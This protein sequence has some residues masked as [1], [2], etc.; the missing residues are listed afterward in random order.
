MCE[1]VCVGIFN[2]WVVC[3]G[4]LVCGFVYVLVL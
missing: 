4:F 2:V 3:M 1:S